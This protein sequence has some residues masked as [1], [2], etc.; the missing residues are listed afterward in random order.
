MNLKHIALYFLILIIPLIFIEC[1]PTYKAS[2]TD[3]DSLKTGN[4]SDIQAK[5]FKSDNSSIIFLH[6]ISV[7][8]NAI[9]GVGLVTG[10]GSNISERQFIKLPFDSIIAMTTYE[11]TTSGGRYFASFLLGLTA[12]PLTFL[13]AYCL[14]CPK[15]CFGS[16]PT[17]YIND[18]SKYYLQAELFSECISRQLEN[19][20]L[21]LL[22]Q[23]I[24]RDTLSLKITNEALETHYINKFDVVVADHPAGTELYP[25][26]DDRLLLISQKEHLLSAFTKD[27][28]EITSLLSADD[29]EYYRSGVEKISQLKEGPVFDWI[30]IKIPASQNSNTKLIL[31]YRNTC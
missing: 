20:D 9:E 25:A 15:C 6:G 18:G 28:S 13:S 10:F 30:D 14:Y 1:F 29:D 22:C 2:K 12:P 19:T 27:G 23:Q 21:D 8:N 26:I 31:K 16:C 4:Y 17:V 7:N 11:E 3:V 24:S 5:V